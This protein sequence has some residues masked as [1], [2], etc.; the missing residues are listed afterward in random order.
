MLTVQGLREF[1]ADVD[2]GLARC[3]NN[4]SFYLRMVSMIFNDGNFDKL[5]AAVADN[6]LKAGFEAAHALKGVLSNLALDPILDPVTEITELLRAGTE[7]DYSGL[8][9]QILGARDEL[10][11]INNA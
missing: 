11:R 6:D 1:G 9:E 5:A 2:Q 3:M 7:T 4:E 8:V 10:V